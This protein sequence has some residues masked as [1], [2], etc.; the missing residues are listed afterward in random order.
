MREIKFRV[1]D[2]EDQKIYYGVGFGES[3]QKFYRYVSEDDNDYKYYDEGMQ[4]TG[5]KDKK[6][7]EIYEGDILR[8]INDFGVH[9]NLVCSCDGMFT[10][11]TLDPMPLS[12]SCT[13]QEIIGN[14]YE[15]KEV[16]E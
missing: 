12:M 16:L 7:K 6:D 13:Y 2:K 1:W 11:D 14:I 10:I 4:Y 5:L 15:N 3:A 9:Y 8:S